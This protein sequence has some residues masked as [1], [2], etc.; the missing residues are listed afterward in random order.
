MAHEVIKRELIQWITKL[1]DDAV[2]D[3][4]KVVKDSSDQQNDWWND[5][6]DDQKSGIARGLSD[7]DSGRVH[8]IKDIR[9]KYGF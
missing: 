1:E 7:V 8:P 6:T 5:L 9:T 4:L 3:Y 2:L